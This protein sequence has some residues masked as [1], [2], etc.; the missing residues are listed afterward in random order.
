MISG[1]ALRCLNHFECI[2]IYGVR[3]YSN[4]I[5]LH[6]LHVL[7]IAVQFSQHHLL[8]RLPFFLITQ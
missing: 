5:V 6:Y 2:S 7:H 8:K 3:N 1:L 4:L